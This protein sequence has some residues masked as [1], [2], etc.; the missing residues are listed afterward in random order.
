MRKMKNT[1]FTLIEVTIIIVMGAILAL[2]MFTYS[3]MS[4]TRG[5]WSLTQTKKTIAQQ[6]VMENI[7]T[8]YNL[9]YKSNL[10]GIKVKIGNTA[11]PQPLTTVYGTYTLIYN[12]FI[13]FVNSGGNQYT[14]APET[15]TANQNTLQVTIKNEQGEKLSILLTNM[16]Q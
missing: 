14:W 15:N 4:F 8:D 1:G 2:M 12:D 13:K 11:S 16:A 5:S 10:A 7:L 3:N 6:K 9:S